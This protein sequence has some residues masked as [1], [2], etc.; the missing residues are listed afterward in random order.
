MKFV[1]TARSVSLFAAALAY[2]IL[3]VNLQAQVRPRVDS[4]FGTVGR[5]GAVRLQLQNYREYQRQNQD[6]VLAGK[7][8]HFVVGQVT[9]RSDEWN[10]DWDWYLVDLMEK[11][12]SLLLQHLLNFTLNVVRSDALPVIRDTW[13]ANRPQLEALWAQTVNGA[14][15]TWKKRVLGVTLY[16]YTV[17]L[18]DTRVSI[19]AELPEIQLTVAPNG[20]EINFSFETSVT[21]STHARGSNGS[22]HASPTFDT[23]LTLGGTIAML[24][25]EKGRYFV[26]KDVYG[27][28][29]TDAQGKIVFTVNILNIGNV[30]FTWNKIDVIVQT[31]IDNA[32]GSGMAQI[33][34]IDLN[35]DGS[36]DLAQ[37]FYF[38]QFLSKTFFAGEPLR[39]QQQILD[40]IFDRDASWIREQIEGRGVRGAVWEIGNEPNWFPLMRPEQYALEFR[41]YYDWI[42]TLDPTAKVM[43]G[44]LFLKEVIDRPEDIAMTLIPPLLSVELRREVAA[45]IS[46]VMFEASTVAWFEAFRAALPAEVEVNIG[47]FHLYPMRA[48]AQAFKLADVEPAIAALCASFQRHQVAEIWATEMGNID[49]R[50]NEAEVATMCAQ[51][52][53]YL[54]EN[55]FG[56]TKWFWSR[57]VGYDRRFDT[58][59]QQPVTALLAND[60]ATL[61]KIGQAYLSAAMRHSEDLRWTDTKLDRGS[62]RGLETD[63]PRELA[64]AANYPNPFS[65]TA[66]GSTHGVTSIPFA[67]PEAREVEVR[68]YDMLGRLTRQI[69][70][71]QQNAGWHQ[72]AWDGRDESGKLVTSGIYFLTLQAG[73]QRL[74]RKLM[75]TK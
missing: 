71:G 36:P 58:I 28:S 30:N 70:R 7:Q 49:W 16:S 37:H 26:L 29:V 3:V 33:K 10:T 23:K 57:S 43:L 72:V 6:P 12:K 2:S 65:L 18:S 75:V 34:N 27:R 51:L 20:E 66:A 9:S 40:G 74:V 47:N 69:V 38:E 24:D 48:E 63:Q 56:I 62:D 21:W 55:Q 61:T 32:V 31:Q 8:K 25:D 19:P 1:T 68:V 14:S 46:N 64:L 67:L 17:R 44:G 4:R 41:R 52:T 35:N 45:F 54:Q 50:R 22:I 73:E 15:K 53:S 11:P 13:N 60:G 39:R 59:G 42:R 5:E